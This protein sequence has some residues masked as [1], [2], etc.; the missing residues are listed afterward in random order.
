[1]DERTDGR[2]KF[3]LHSTGYCPSRTAA[4]FTIWKSEQKEKQGKGI[5]D[6]ICGVGGGGGTV[7]G[8]IEGPLEALALE[9]VIQ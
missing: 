3:P 7:G 2:T 1:M 5:A 9:C 8:G 6:Y 4:L